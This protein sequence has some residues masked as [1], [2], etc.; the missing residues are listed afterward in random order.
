MPQKHVDLEH[1]PE[2]F[3]CYLMYEQVFAQVHL[4]EPEPK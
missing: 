1:V 3:L 4:S 2:P